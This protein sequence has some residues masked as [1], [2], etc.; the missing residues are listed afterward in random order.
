MKRL[1]T[2]ILV[3]GGGATG[4]GVA[5][6]AS[7]RGFKVILVERRDLTH[8]TSGR[9]HGLLHS[10]GRYAVKD[11]ASAAECIAE[12]RIL[13][14]THT[15]CIEDT[16]GFFVV[17][18]EDESDYPD[19]FKSS[20][21]KVGIPCD[22]IAPAEAFRREPLLNRRISRVF[23]VPD[24]SA[25]S[26]LAAHATAQAA[27]Q[28]GAQILTYHEVTGLVTN[29]Q[30]VVGARVTNVATGE[31]LEIHADVTVNAAGAWSGRLAKMAGIEVVI[32]ASKG[33]MIAMNHRLVNTVINRCK[34]PADGDILVPSHTVSVI[35]TT[36]INVPDPEPLRITTWEVKK[37]MDEGEKM[38]P[39]FK[40]ARVLRAWAGVR[41]L[42]Q[43]TYESGKG[44]DVTRQIALLDHREREGVSGFLTITGGKWTTFRMMAEATV[45]N[46]C[47]HLGVDRPCTT[48]S[49]PVPGAEQGHYWLGHGLHEIEEERLQGNLVCECELVTRNMVENAAR[50]N[51]TLTVDDLRRE[52]RLGMGPCQGTFCTYRAVGILHEL[53]KA[54]T[55][56]AD[57]SDEAETS[58]QWKVAHLQSP[59]HNLTAAGRTSQTTTKSGFN[60]NL[61]LRDFLQERWKGI[62]P[63]LWGPQLKQERMD[64]LI[65]L[66]LMNADHL[67]EAEAAGPMTEFYRF[68][69]TPAEEP[70]GGADD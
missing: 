32:M 40:K 26:F 68:D 56:N 51:P 7:L 17:T 30:G 53:M 8:G 66:S 29:D 42:F 55:W 2:E 1:N 38:L 18:P 46:I 44:R 59:A 4:T 6:D 3:I 39:D 22:E 19:R 67:P 27:R 28:A 11:P 31:E 65:Y 41:P 50:G 63:V 9:Y 15:H 37:L 43:E 24:G 64:E 34:M 48:A 16:G 33:T 12:N 57:L 45:D 14:R 20:C 60:P 36:S 21:E 58:A 49:T 10:G 13:R 61:A 69:N 23:E 35:G 52:T 5:W 62:T 47:R 54:G 70:E 25:D